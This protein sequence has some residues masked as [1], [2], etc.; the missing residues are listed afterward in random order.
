[1]QVKNSLFLLVCCFSVVFMSGCGERTPPFYPVQGAVLLDGKPVSGAVVSF[2]SQTHEG[3]VATGTTDG[4]GVF[5]L[6]SPL[7]GKVGSGLPS[8][9]YFVTVEKKEIKNP[10]KNIEK[11][12]SSQKTETEGK[13]TQVE[14]FKPEFLYHIPEKYASTKTSGL[15]ASVKEKNDAMVFHL[16][17]DGTDTED[18]TTEQGEEK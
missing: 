4:H 16:Q 13:A 7:S 9:E 11:G 6:S 12:I 17:M 15:T 14:E 1:M 8:G 5:S 3:I 10:P 18:S 2:I